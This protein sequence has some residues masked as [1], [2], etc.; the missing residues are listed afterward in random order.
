LTKEKNLNFIALSE[1]GRKSFSSPF[2]K[3][4]CAGRDFLWHIKEPRGRSGGILLGIDLSRFDIGAIEEGVFFVKFH[5]C[6]KEDSFKWAL[7][8]VYGP[9]QEDQKPTFLSELVNMGSRENLPLLVGGDFNILRSR[10][11]KNNDNFNE[12]W[13]FLFNAVIDGLNLREIEMLGRKFTW[14]NSLAQPTYEK[15]DRILVAMDWEQKYPLSTVTTLSR[16]ISDHTPLF[17]DM[18]QNSSGSNYNQ[19]KFELGWLL[20]DGFR[21]MVTDIWVNENKGG[22]VMERWQAKIRKLWQHLR[23]WAKNVSGT[24]KKERIVR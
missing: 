19:F 9:A 13:L 5:L 17:L 4:M 10:D 3:N 7:V 14:A 20:R 21:E 22:S 8:A 23:G 2:L 16:D 24:Y 15:L 12:R 6:N 18:V 11:E 1:I